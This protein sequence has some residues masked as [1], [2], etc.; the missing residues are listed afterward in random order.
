MLF[1]CESFEPE[2]QWTTGSQAVGSE[3]VHLA[4]FG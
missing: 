3:K 2:W 4:S 1:L